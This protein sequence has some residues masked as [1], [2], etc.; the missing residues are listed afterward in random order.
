M[1]TTI[2]WAPTKCDGFFFLYCG[3]LAARFLI[4]GLV[5]IVFC[6]EIGKWDFVNPFFGPL[7]HGTCLY[8]KNN[9]LLGECSLQ[10]KTGSKLLKNLLYVWIIIGKCS[11]SCWQKSFL[12]PQ[13]GFVLIAGSVLYTVRLTRGNPTPSLAGVPGSSEKHCSEALWVSE[14]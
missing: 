10:N 2:L 1:A 8:K 4:K 12:M 7:W 9:Q 3:A 14:V 6:N 13:R 5:F 11:I